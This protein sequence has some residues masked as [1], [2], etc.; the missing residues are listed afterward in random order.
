M[1]EQPIMYLKE[2]TWEDFFKGRPETWERAYQAFEARRKAEKKLKSDYKTSIPCSCKCPISGENFNA[3]WNPQYV[4]YRCSYLGDDD[5]CTHPSNN[6]PEPECNHTDHYQR[7]PDG[8]TKEHKAVGIS[9]RKD[10]PKIPYTYCIRCEVVLSVKKPKCKHGKTRGRNYVD[11]K[12]CGDKHC[13][14]CG[15]KLTGVIR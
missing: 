7:I 5:I 8:Y 4:S 15:E 12:E 6:L 11:Y 2:Q 9:W 13:R 1:N 3:T 10:S 14:D